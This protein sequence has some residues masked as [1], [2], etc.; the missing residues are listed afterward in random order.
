MN[1][2]GTLRRWA[3]SIGK[4][5]TPPGNHTPI[6]ESLDG[7]PGPSPGENLGPV[8]SGPGTR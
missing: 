1:A 2:V 8:Q 6:D 7:R 4:R 5:L 3:R